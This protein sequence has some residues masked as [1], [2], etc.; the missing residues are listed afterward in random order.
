MSDNN[1]DHGFRSNRTRRGLLRRLGVAAGGTTLA[2]GAANLL[3][4]PTA[5][6]DASEFTASDTPTV[7]N[8][9]GTV[10]A[11]YVAPTMDVYWEHFGGGVQEVAVTLE[12]TVDGKTDVVYSEVLDTIDDYGDND[13][14]ASTSS[15]SS[16]FSDTSGD[17][18]IEFTQ[19]DITAVGT[20]VTADDFSDGTLDAGD[21]KTTQVDLALTVDVVGNQNEDGTVVVS[22]SFV[23]EVA[24]PDGTTEIQGSANTDAQ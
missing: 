13:D 16:T 20:A 11:V 1:D 24:N 5:A 22:D 21:S 7:E 9:D 2:A 10:S 8:S 6:V 3:A 12:A 23:V 18:T 4:E 14:I 19:K 15:V 17:M